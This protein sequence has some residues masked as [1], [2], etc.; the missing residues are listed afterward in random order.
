VS[1]SY[2]RTTALDKRR[3]SLEAWANYVTG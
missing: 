2:R 1:R 3:E